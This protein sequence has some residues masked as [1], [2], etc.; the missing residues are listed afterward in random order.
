ME[1]DHLQGRPVVNYIIYN[2]I[3]L[4]ESGERTQLL[5]SSSKLKKGKINT[6]SSWVDVTNNIV[7]IGGRIPPQSNVR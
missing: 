1:N 3:I 5:R 4:K 6:P 2:K 7:V